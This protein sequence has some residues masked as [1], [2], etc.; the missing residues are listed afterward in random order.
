MSRAILHA[1]RSVNPT[2][3]GTIE[4]LK[5]LAL[6]HRE[7][8]HAVEVAS[9]DLPDDPWVREFPL[10]IQALGVP[11]SASGGGYGFSPNY[12]PWLAQNAARFRAVIVHGLWQ[13]HGYGTARALRGKATPHFVFPHG[14]LD[15]WFRLA[16]PVKHLKKQLYWLWREHQVLSS[17]RAVLFTCEEERSLARGTFRPYRV[18]ERIVPLGLAQP[19]ADSEAQ[20]TA[21]FERF[22]GLKQKRVLLFLGRLHDKKGCDM[23][24]EAFAG[25]SQKNDR[26]FHL[27]LAGPCADQSYLERLQRLSAQLC[28]PASVSFPGMLSGDVKWGALRAAEAFILPSH[29][30]NFGLAVVEA[31]ACG[32]PVLIANKVNIWREIE[33][34]GGGLV[35]SDDAAGTA[36]LLERWAALADPD[37]MRTAAR[38]CFLKRFEIRHVAKELIDVIES[39]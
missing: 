11:A 14:M 23:L 20:R 3:G 15:P 27:A 17:A 6:V 8:G 9:L 21:F 5:Q 25:F 38:E 24:I 1:I 19:P 28:K 4:A 31:L 16:Y 22:P 2:S 30:E 29:Q 39:A 12:I 36:R 18:T 10:P 26:A 35:E 33:Q 32:V 13:F 34:D 37:A 7:M